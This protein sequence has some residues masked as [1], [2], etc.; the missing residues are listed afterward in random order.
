MGRWKVRVVFC[1]GLARFVETQDYGIVFF[2]FLDGFDDDV[3]VIEMAQLVALAFAGGLAEEGRGEGL[4]EG[5]GFPHH[6]LGPEGPVVGQDAVGKFM[7]PLVGFFVRIHGGTEQG[8]GEFL[9]QTVV[10]VFTIVEEGHTIVPFGDIHPLV[11]TDFE[12]GFIPAGVWRAWGVP[13]GQTESRCAN[14]RP[15]R[16]HQNLP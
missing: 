7:F 12:A 2:G 5:T 11:C 13:H 10:P 16:P 15:A 6:A 1:P 3:G 14:G 8:D 4:V 9:V